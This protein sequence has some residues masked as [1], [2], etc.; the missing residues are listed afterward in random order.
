M[1]YKRAAK[2]GFQEELG[3]AVFNSEGPCD[4]DFLD[5]ER[6]VF[7]EEGSIPSGLGFVRGDSEMVL[8]VVELAAQT[9]IVGS[10]QQRLSKH[11]FPLFERRKDDQLKRRACQTTE[12]LVRKQLVLDP[13]ALHPHTLPQSPR[14]HPHYIHGEVEEEGD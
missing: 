1:V 8:E 10:P 7:A 13:L 11:L 14:V 2:A 9:Q 3:D 5:V 12:S 4:E 6:D